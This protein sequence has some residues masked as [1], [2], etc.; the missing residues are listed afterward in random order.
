[1]YVCMYCMYM[2]TKILWQGDTQP[3]HNCTYLCP[4]K[5][6]ELVELTSSQCAGSMPC[7]VQF[8]TSSLELTGVINGTGTLKT[9]SKGGIHTYI[10]INCLRTLVTE[11]LLSRD[12][13]GFIQL[14]LHLS[15]P[16]DKSYFGWAAGIGKI[17]FS[18]RLRLL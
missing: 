9:T 4:A 17:R 18:P 6:G 3:L 8:N 10:H 7:F 2:Y 5:V 16:R 15:R 13:S 1:M 14:Q 12:G 11:R